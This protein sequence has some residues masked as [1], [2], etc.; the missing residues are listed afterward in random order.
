MGSLTESSLKNIIFLLFCCI[1]FAND[2]ESCN[3]LIFFLLT[4]ELAKM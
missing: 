3:F 4:I 1:T 2:Q